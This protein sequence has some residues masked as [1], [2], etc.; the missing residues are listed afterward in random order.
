V[1]YWYWLVFLLVYGT[2][3]LFLPLFLFGFCL[4]ASYTF[5]WLRKDDAVSF[6][7]I[8][9]VASAYQTPMLVCQTKFPPTSV[10]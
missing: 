7:T 3:E 2:A 5:G 4:L 6:K 8:R 10:K 1:T 9:R